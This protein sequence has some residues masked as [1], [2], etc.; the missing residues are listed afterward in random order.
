MARTRETATPTVIERFVKSLVV[1]AKAVTLYPPASNVPLETA[2]KTVSLLDEALQARSELR[3]VIHPD[4]IVYAGAPVYPGAE[5]YRTFAADLHARGL[6]EVRF[7]AGMTTR[8]LVAF[9]SL[10]NFTPEQARD[11]GGFERRLWERGVNSISVSS[12][13]EDGLDGG[14][15][16]AQPLPMSDREFEA[17]VERL[18]EEPDPAERQAIVAALSRVAAD[19]IPRL[20]QHLGDSRWYVVRNVVSLL[21]AAGSAEVVSDLVGALAHAEPRVRREAIRA[22]AVI[23]DERA[24]RGLVRALEDSDAG[25]VQLAARYLGAARLT[26]AV[27]ALILV[28]VGEGEGNRSPGPRN[29]AIEA[30]GLIGAQEAV[31]AL[32]SLATPRRLP[33]GPKA[34]GLKLA[35]EAAIA[36]ISERE[37]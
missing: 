37:D 13:T 22:L 6:A 5:A 16:A 3:L 32:M 14:V 24:S 35:A 21:G 9:L 4:A 11:A 25:N 29:E 33:R 8:D 1:S 18:A 23:D 2:E 7:H 12:V 20:R 17:A 15:G 31:P 26:E 36:R 34:R 27:P 30:L 28:A 10:L 19:H